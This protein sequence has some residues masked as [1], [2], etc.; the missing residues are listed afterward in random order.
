MKS[1]AEFKSITKDWVRA[2]HSVN[3]FLNEEY[4]MKSENFG[5]MHWHIT[6]QNSVKLGNFLVQF[7]KQLIFTTLC[8]KKNLVATVGSF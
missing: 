7:R 4:S 1:L 6:L 2:Y 3:Y 8:I 5:L